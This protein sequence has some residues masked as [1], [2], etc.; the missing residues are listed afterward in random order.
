MF[1]N[2]KWHLGTNDSLGNC[3]LVFNRVDAKRTPNI[4]KNNPVNFHLYF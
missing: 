2:E 3:V 4:I 1:S